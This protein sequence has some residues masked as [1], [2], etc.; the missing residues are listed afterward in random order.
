MHMV[1]IPQGGPWGGG[2]RGEGQCLLEKIA[3]GS[4]IFG[5]KEFLLTSFFDNLPWD[6]MVYPPPPM[7][8]PVEELRCQR[9]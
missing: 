4:L 6:P 3:W 1:K 7:C 2:G 9:S 5:F 8:A